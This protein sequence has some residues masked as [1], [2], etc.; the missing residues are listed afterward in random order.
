MNSQIDDNQIKRYPVKI[1]L[2]E[3]FKSPIALKQGFLNNLGK[4]QELPNFPSVYLP[5]SLQNKEAATKFKLVFDTIDSRDR[6]LNAL[7]NDEK[8]VNPCEIADTPFCKIKL[9]GFTADA[10]KHENQTLRDLCSYLKVPSSYIKFLFKYENNL[11]QNNSWTLSLLLHPNL[12]KRL[13]SKGD[14][15]DIH[16]QDATMSLHVEDFHVPILCKN[17]GKYGHSSKICRLAPNNLNQCKD[18]SHTTCNKDCPSFKQLFLESKI[19][20]EFV[21]FR[22]TKV[23]F[24]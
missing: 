17:C 7:R 21:C 20:S 4:E 10:V 18:C 13:Y 3:K 5:E 8:L 15:L 12:R 2:N 1:T 6:W 23:Y 22:M 14:F 24:A 11:S 9:H 16:Y 19:F